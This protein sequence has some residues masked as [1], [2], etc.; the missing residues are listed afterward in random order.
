MK[1]WASASAV[2]FSVVALTTACSS[3]APPGNTPVTPIGGTSAGGAGGVATTSGTTSGGTNGVPMAGTSTGGTVTTTAGTSMGGSV[4]VAGTGGTAPV[5]G[6]GGTAP[7]GGTGGTAPVGGAGAEV[8][9][10][11]PAGVVGHCSMGVTYPP[12][13]GFTLQ[14]VEDF[15]MPLD[16]DHDPIWTWSDG[17]PADGQT[18]FRKDQLGFPNGHMT[19]TADAPAGCAPMTS[20]AGCIPGR[21]AYG[22][23]LNPNAQANVGT[24]GVWSGELRTKY[25]NYRYGYYEVKYQAPVANPGME[26]TDTA[27]GDY[28]STM[29]IFRTPKNVVWNEIDIELE[30]NHHNQIGG[31][32]VNAQG[33]VGYP[34]GNADPLMGVNGPAGYAITQEHIYA[35]SWTPTK[36]EWFMDGVSI[37]SFAGRPGTGPTNSDPIPTLSA[38]IMMNLWVFSGNAFGDGKNNK[39]PFHATYDYLHF[40]KFSGEAKYPCDPVPGCLDATDKTKSAQNNGT[41][42]NYGM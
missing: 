25:N 20:N 23:A 42:V 35:F 37:H 13:D 29:F 2:G 4:P 3:D 14:L 36:V 16:L 30:P 31:N 40:Y 11:C 8:M 38:K 33:A 7:V 9:T 5:G 15:P 26:M 32:V 12:H 10:A 18:G 27:S 17:S 22:E 34:G 39:Y 28:L 19:I 41:E 1:L 6:T 21:M 24:M